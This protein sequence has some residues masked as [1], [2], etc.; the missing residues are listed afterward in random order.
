M[1]YQLAW[2]ALFASVLATSL[3]AAVPAHPPAFITQPEGRV[4]HP[5]WFVQLSVEVTGTPP[6]WFEWRKDDV[7][8]A[9]APGDFLMLTFAWTVE[10]DTGG[11]SVIVTNAFGAVTSRVAQVEVTTNR[12]SFSTEP[13]DRVVCTGGAETIDTFVRSGSPVF[14]QWQ[15][16]G[17]NLPGANQ[18]SLELTNIGPAD[19]GSYRLVAS[20]AFGVTVSREARL[21]VDPPEPVIFAHPQSQVIAEGDWLSMSV[22]ARS[23]SDL[24]YQWRLNGTNLPGLEASWFEAP[25]VTGDYDV[26]VTSPSG[27]VTS[28]LATV[29]IEQS[30]PV[31]TLEPDSAEL[32]AG[33]EACFTVWAEGV[34]YPQF[35][36][37]FNGTAIAGATNENLCFLVLSTNQIGDY[38]AIAWNPA[39]AVTS[40]VA[41]LTMRMF[42]PE[43]QSEPEDQRVFAGDY[44]YLLFEVSA[45]PL[46]RFQWF[47]N[48]TAIP[49]ATNSWLDL[50]VISTNQSGRYQAVAWNPRGAVL[51][52]AME[53][54]VLTELPQIYTQPVSQVVAQGQ[55]LRL[56]VGAWGAPDPVFQWRR[57]GVDIPGATNSLLTLYDVTT[58]DSGL[59][60]VVASN[61]AGSTNSKRALVRV[62]SAGPLEHWHW[63]RPTPQGNDVFALAEGNGVVVAV[64]RAGTRMVSRDGGLTWENHNDDHGD[65]DPLAFGNGVFVALGED[66]YSACSTNGV[67]WDYHPLPN[68]IPY[69]PTVPSGLAFGNGSFVAVYYDGRSILSSNGVDWTLPEPSGSPWFG[70]ATFGNGRFYTL[71]WIESEVP[72]EYAYALGCSTNGSEWEFHPLNPPLE[73]VDIGWCGDRLAVT[74]FE[75]PN[76]AA[77]MTSLDGTNWT[78][79]NL[80]NVG[81]LKAPTFGGGRF[82]A[83]SSYGVPG[84]AS[85]ADGVQWDFHSIQ[86]TNGLYSAAYVGGRFIVAGDKGNIV[87]SSNGSDWAAVSDGS[88]VNFRSV[89]HGNGRYVAVGNEGLVVTSPDGTTWTRTAPPTTNNLRGVAFGQG[90]FVAVGDNDTLGGTVLVSTNGATWARLPGIVSRGFYDLVYAAGRFVAVGDA[91]NTLVSSDGLAWTGS[92]ASI[93]ERINAVNWGNGSFVAVGRNGMILSSTDGA[94]WIHRPAPDEFDTYLQGVAFG[95]GRWLAAGKGGRS[96]WSTN[97]EAWLE[98]PSRVPGLY[99][100]GVEDLG[101][102]NGQFFAVGQDGLMATSAD[103][104]FWTLRSTRCQNDLRAVIEA[105]GRILAVG[106]NETILQ[107]EYWGPPR[108][109]VQ[110]ESGAGFVFSVDGEMG[111]TYRLQA[112][113][114]LNHWEDVFTFSS[115]QTTTWYFD[116]ASFW[117]PRRFFRVVSP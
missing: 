49:G 13:Y 90:R 98:S 54:T 26:V 111:A 59:Y 85:S 7:P 47:L 77:I 105:D 12:P 82:I 61:E 34:P 10:G 86:P 20:N 68:L 57:D 113:E 48:G 45:S 101:I 32:A 8:L 44:A 104:E 14:F 15:H 84:V 9:G 64:G 71:A 88:A 4:V 30:P 106:N 27:A 56:F 55:T 92:Q 107:S 100:P 51:S 40:Q 60:S 95:N 97:L 29:V 1:K 66:G 24:Q 87:I 108:L 94:N 70:R 37:F 89:T 83:V 39:G 91:G 74:A 79:T 18:M 35:Q 23:C 21:W 28:L 41:R 117:L 114:D 116:E 102:A 36:W 96:V 109:R 43:V 110:P 63:R 25:T 46:A 42:P 38:Q 31:V 58:N 2:G 65:L 93:G 73:P 67:T 53:L 78:S 52:R 19:A 22:D 80:L 112:S 6:F 76:N 81:R 99:S 17:T 69:S 11:Y 33:E 50:Q 103:G 5:G 62:V 72:G 115:S 75:Y 3:A 16:S